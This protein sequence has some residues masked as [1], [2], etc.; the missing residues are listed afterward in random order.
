MDVLFLRAYPSTGMFTESL[1]SNMSRYQDFMQYIGTN[2]SE[3][4]DTSN[5]RV[6]QLTLKMKAVCYFETLVPIYQITSHIP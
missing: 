1:P 4:P 3:E 5:F 6:K 2:V